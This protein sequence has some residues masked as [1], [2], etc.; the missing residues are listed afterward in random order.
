MLTH[1]DIENMIVVALQP[2]HIENDG[3]VRVIKT[4]QGDLETEE[5]VR[6]ALSLFPGLFV[7]WAGA[8]YRNAGCCQYVEE[9]LYCIM[10]AD[11]SLRGDGSARHGS[12]TNPGVYTLLDQVRQ[13]LNNHVLSA[14]LSPMEIDSERPLYFSP[15]VSVYGAYY[16][17]E[18]VFIQPVIKA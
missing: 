9:D 17:L 10:V 6:K 7:S 16:K 12:I 15:G 18:Q 1:T 2:L 14:A 3:K 5:Q 11:K 4:Y 13:E 8:G